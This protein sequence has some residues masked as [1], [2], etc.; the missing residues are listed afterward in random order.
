MAKKGAA[1]R[2]RTKKRKSQQTAVAVEQLIGQDR[3]QNGLRRE[4]EHLVADAQVLEAETTASQ[5]KPSRQQRRAVER[6]RQKLEGRTLRLLE[7]NDEVVREALL[8]KERLSGIIA[9]DEATEGDELL[10]FIAEELKFLRRRRR[11]ST[12]KRARRSD[13]GTCIRHWCSTCSVWSVAS[14]VCPAAPIS[15]PLFCATSVG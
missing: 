8:R 6:R 13:A 1:S 12:R 7:R 10:W 2:G 4:A 3:N 5:A 15:R 11:E 9:A 14:W